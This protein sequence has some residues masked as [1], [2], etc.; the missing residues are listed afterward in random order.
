MRILD[1]VEIEINKIV[2]KNRFMDMIEN[3]IDYNIYTILDVAP[4]ASIKELKSKL[5]MMLLACHPDQNP[6]EEK[7]ICEK[8]IRILDMVKEDIE[9]L[10]K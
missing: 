5:R 4:K 3:N 1:K 8:M 2:E 10:E 9:D 6:E 7:E